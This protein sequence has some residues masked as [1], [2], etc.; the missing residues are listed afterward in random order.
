MI[1]PSPTN[2][3]TAGGAEMQMAAQASAKHGPAHRARAA[4][5]DD[6]MQ[7]YQSRFVAYAKAQGVTPEAMAAT[8]F[9]AG[10]ICWINAKW[11][12]FCAEF[13]RSRDYHTEQDHADFDAW[14]EAA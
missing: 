13:K 8:R 11:S 12:A 7:T 14:L 4:E 9:G 1:P 6:E 2:N 5:G 3:G 10:F